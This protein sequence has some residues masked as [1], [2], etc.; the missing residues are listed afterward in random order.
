MQTKVVFRAR[1]L[2]PDDNAAE[3]TA[4]EVVND[5]SVV[6]VTVNE[7]YPRDVGNFTYD[8]RGQVILNELPEGINPLEHLR[9]SVNPRSDIVT[10]QFGTEA[11]L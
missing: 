9:S 7:G 11:E 3:V 5:E 4:R 2:A 6:N 1:I 10:V 8:V